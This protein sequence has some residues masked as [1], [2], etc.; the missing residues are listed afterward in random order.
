MKIILIVIPKSLYNAFM[1]TL[2]DFWNPEMDSM[3]LNPHNF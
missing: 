1:R 3:R 2:R